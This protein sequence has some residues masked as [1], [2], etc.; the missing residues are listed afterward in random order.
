M[1]GVWKQR[2]GKAV[3][4]WGKMMNDELAAIAGKYEE[5]VGRLQE[6]YGIASEKSKRR[7]N[8]FR[9]VVAQLKKS[10]ANLV[11]LQAHL[12]NAES[13]SGKIKLGRL[14]RGK[15]RSRSRR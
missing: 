2:R 6:R 11:N 9:R 4:H 15:P 8:D 13:K 1:E 14:P 7:D 5:L 3:H 12:K 10:N